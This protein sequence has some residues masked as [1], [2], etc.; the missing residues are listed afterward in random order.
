[1]I[2]FQVIIE[3]VNFRAK[4]V[5]NNFFQTATSSRAAGNDGDWQHAG[6]QG[7]VAIEKIKPQLQ[8]PRRYHVVMINDD[9]TPM[10]FVVHVL[11]VFFGMT[12]ELATRTMLKVHTE[13]K[14]VCGVY[15]RDV[16]ETKAGQVNHYSQQNQHPLL[17]QIAAAAHDDGDADP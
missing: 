6:N 13:G 15:T 1:L 14:A 3:A 17:C 5:S 16:A 10:D 8:L 2:F 12:T 7:A 4:Q 9:Y 11:C